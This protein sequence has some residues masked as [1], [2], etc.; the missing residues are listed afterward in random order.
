M[1]DYKVAVV[2]ST[3]AEYGLLK[4]VI[5]SLSDTDGINVMVVVTGAH[6]LASQGSTISEIRNDGTA[7]AACIDIYHGDASD[8]AAAVANAVTGFAAW[9]R[10]ERPDLV[11][12]LGDR[13]EIFGVAAAASMCGI[14][15]AHISGGETTEGAKDEFYRHCITK[16]SAIHFPST[17]RYRKRIIQLGERPSAVFNVGS[18]GAQNVLSVPLM[19]K[20]ALSA[21]VGFDFSS[22]FLL[23]TCHPETLGSGADV[24]IPL[25]N[26][27][28]R[29]GIPVLF[30]AANADAEGD[31]INQ[32]ISEFC[33]THPSCKLVQSLGYRRYL[34]ALKLCS[35]VVGNSS[36]SLT[37]AP[38]MRKPSVNIGIRQLGRDMTDT[39][40]SCPSDEGAIISAVRTALSSEFR[41]VC[42]NA[43]LPFRC[44]GVSSSIAEIVKRSLESGIS[45]KK[46]FYDIDFEVR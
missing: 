44:E 39:V 19:D 18:L 8:E 24:C 5:A 3:R 4:P 38:A 6:L 32:R 35:A 29:L 17:E 22:S 31:I 12:L 16:M 13:Y 14:P 41:S 36:S 28:D 21:S 9:F 33:G 42:E 40:I 10:S 26:A 15:I 34:S 1:A 37:E 43:V 2:T 11:V 45:C 30:T 23:C 27:I 25:L 46:S 7:I 20:D